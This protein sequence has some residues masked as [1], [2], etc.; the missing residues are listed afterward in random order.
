M[1]LVMGCCATLLAFALMTP[2][3]HAGWPTKPTKPRDT[4]APT[5]PTGLRVVAATEDSLTLAWNAS[6]DTSCS[7][8]HY[9]VSPGSWHPGDSTQKTISWLVPSYTQT[10]RV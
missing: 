3:A 7:I 5:V 4:T 8:H 6:T 9:V 1:K 2:A 10:Y